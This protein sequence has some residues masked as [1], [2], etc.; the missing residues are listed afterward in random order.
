MN[1]SD[2]RAWIEQRFGVSRGTVLEKL[3][4][5]IEMENE[6]QNLVSPSTL[7]AIWDRH[8]VDS[9]QLV[10]LAARAVGGGPWID[11]GAGAGFPGLVAA[12]L[13][14]RPVI[15]V[16]PRRLRAD[17]LSRAAAE[18]GLTNIEVVQA[19]IERVAIPAAI[20][21]ARAVARLGSL[22]TAAQRC[23][24]KHTLWLLPKGRSVQEE[25]AEARQAWHG[26]FHVEPSLTSRDS[27]IVIATG[28]APR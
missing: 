26:V 7:S 19:R 21:S 15:L 9:A 1:E 24:G 25:V 22:F 13:I 10:P 4:H 3:V 12:A 27:A 20:I 28:V 23:V 11:V 5:L 18:M 6:R 14:D 2:A 16:E 8:I 17:F